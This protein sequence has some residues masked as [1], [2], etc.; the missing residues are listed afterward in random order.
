MMI[1]LPRNQSTQI[2]N[3]IYPNEKKMD[4][5]LHQ[6]NIDII[7]SK[8]IINRQKKELEDNYVPGIK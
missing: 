7:K 5:V 2:K 4:K 6:K 3:M 8:Q 1:K